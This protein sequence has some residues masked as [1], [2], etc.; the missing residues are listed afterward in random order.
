MNLFLDFDGVIDDLSKNLKTSNATHKICFG[1][2][3]NWNKDWDG[4]RCQTWY[5]I[6]RILL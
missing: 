1:E 4:I 3:F 5:D 6:K 2:K